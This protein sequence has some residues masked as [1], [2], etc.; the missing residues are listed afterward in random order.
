MPRSSLFRE[1]KAVA[2]NRSAEMETQT[3]EDAFLGSPILWPTLPDASE[4]ASEKALQ[5]LNRTLP[6]EM[7]LEFMNSGV[8]QYSGRRGT[9]LIASHSQTKIYSP[10]G[11][12]C[13]AYACLQL[14]T[15]APDYDRMLAE[16]LLLKNDEDRYWNT[17]NMFGPASDVAVFFLAILDI[18][19]FLYLLRYF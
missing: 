16:Y 1:F 2:L 12:H 18:C 4:S 11:R 5:L 19:W 14:S 3:L 7:W 6:D 15:P 17:A 13:L 10:A 8:I 9:Y